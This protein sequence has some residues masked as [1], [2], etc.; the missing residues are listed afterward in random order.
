M[1]HMHVHTSIEHGHLP[2]YE[3]S[4]H[5]SLLTLSGVPVVGIFTVFLG[6]GQGCATSGL[7]LLCL[8]PMFSPLAG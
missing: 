6:A 7:G 8:L 1:K 3:K 5:M 4:I 2:I